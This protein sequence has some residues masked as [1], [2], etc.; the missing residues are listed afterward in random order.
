MDLKSIQIAEIT[1]Y[2]SKAH[3]WKSPGND[4]IQISWLKAFPATH[5]H[6][7]KNVN[8]IIE[9]P[10]KAPDW[11]TTGITYFISKSGDSK[12][13]ETTDPLHA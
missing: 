13:S 2:L 6:I 1:S 12:E 3:S 10:E 5:R 7:T 9:Q 8:A 11:L 4:K